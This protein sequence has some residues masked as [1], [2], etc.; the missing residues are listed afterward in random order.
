VISKEQPHSQV[1]TLNFIGGAF[2]NMPKFTTKF[3]GYIINLAN[4]IHQFHGNVV[5]HIPVYV[6]IN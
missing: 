1:K 2:E 5:G 3:N 4:A 6:N